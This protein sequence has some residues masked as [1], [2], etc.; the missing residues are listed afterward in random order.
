MPYI[1]IKCSI[2]CCNVVQGEI[3]DSQ[4]VLKYMYINVLAALIEGVR[5][6]HENSMHIMT[7]LA[8]SEISFVFGLLFFSFPLGF[9]M[10]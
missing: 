1:Y 4:Y 2:F 10:A 6:M 8:P 7:V 9:V 5:S 3:A